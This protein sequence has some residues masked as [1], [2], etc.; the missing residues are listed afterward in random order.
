MRRKSIELTKARHTLHIVKSGMVA[1]SL[2]LRLHGIGVGKEDHIIKFGVQ[3]QI[4]ILLVNGVG[5]RKESHIQGI[6]HTGVEVLMLIRPVTAKR[7]RENARRKGVTGPGHLTTIPV[8]NTRKNMHLVIENHLIKTEVESILDTA[9][10]E[11]KT[12]HSVHEYG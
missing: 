3:H 1:Q 7:K 12:L 4:L 10:I 8:M 11:V 5:V 6:E 2:I 9:G